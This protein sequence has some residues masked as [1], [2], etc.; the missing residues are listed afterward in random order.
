MRDQ[1][2]YKISLCNCHFSQLGHTVNKEGQS[3]Y[4]D[5]KWQQKPPQVPSF[6]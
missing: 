5:Y 4:K 2:M 3:S 1:L 6:L